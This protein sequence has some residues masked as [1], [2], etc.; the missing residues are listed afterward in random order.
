MLRFHI[1]NFQ[2]LK[3]SWH[4]NFVFTSST[5]RISR[6]H[7][8][9]ASFFGACVR[10]SFAFCNSLFADRSGVA[11]SRFPVVAAACVILLCF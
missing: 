10:N 2:T 8:T 3:E 9:K 6:K 7:C 1:C 11:A 5:L 4:E